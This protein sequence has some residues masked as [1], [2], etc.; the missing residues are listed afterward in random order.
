MKISN[1]IFLSHAAIGFFS[2]GI[3]SFIFSF[4]LQD[5]LIQRTVDQLSSINILKKNQIDNYFLRIQKQFEFLLTHNLSFK[6]TDSKDV[7]SSPKQ[8]QSKF[9]REIIAVRNLN[10]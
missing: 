9:N 1:K 2:L 4:I 3:L 6:E 7:V 5:A 10:D 8:F